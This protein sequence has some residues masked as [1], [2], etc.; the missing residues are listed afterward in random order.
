M[1]TAM[2]DFDCD[3]L[4]IGGGINGVGIARDAAGRGLRVIL[5]EKDDLA[6]HTSSASSKLIHGGLRYLEYYEFALVRKA[7]QEREVLMRLAPHIISARRFIMPHQAH[8]RSQWLIRAGLFLYD[9][10]ARRDLLPASSAI[11]LRKHVAGAPLKADMVQGFEY[12]DAWVDDARLVVLNAVSAAELGAQICCRTECL[13]LQRRDSAWYAELGNR[14]GVLRRVRA[15]AVVNASGAW[16]A[17]L[18]HRYSPT[19]PRKELRLVQGSHIVVKRLFEH[20][21]AY[22]FQNSDGRIV[23]ALPYESEYTLVG[24]TDLEFKG[25][26]NHPQIS[27]AE[28][29]YLLNLCNHYFQ[30]QIGVKDIVWTYSGVRPLV[31]DGKADAKAIT[32]DY[33]LE[34]D[35]SGAPILHIFGGKI[36]TFRKLAEQACDQLLA[37]LGRSNQAWTAHAVLPGGDLFQAMPSNQNVKQFEQFCE[38]ACSAYPFLP[39][40]L[41]RRYVSLY[42]TRLHQMLKDCTALENLGQEVLPSLYQVEIEYLRSCEFAVTAQDILWR[43]TKLGLHCGPEAASV[44]E[45][46]L[47]AHPVV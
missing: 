4:V 1:S 42:G 11:D 2:N 33:R 32:R 37:A 43:R 10:L 16:A 36:T 41:V 46:W 3:V 19:L 17:E 6:S 8:L 34:L 14:Q 30:K 9:Q 22:I 38:Q 40:T 31:D 18:Q 35:Q 5:C 7:L 29:E 47:V 12:S 21:Y 44:L 28:I 24:T 26:Q 13:D 45:T 25:D 27:A 15:R 20:D 23:F 39:S